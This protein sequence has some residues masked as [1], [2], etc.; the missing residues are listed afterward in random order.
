[1][2]SNARCYVYTELYYNIDDFI[3]RTNK[4]NIL[5]PDYLDTMDRI[6]SGGSGNSALK[7]LIHDDNRQQKPAAAMVADGLPEGCGRPH[8]WLHQ[9]VPTVPSEHP[10]GPD[11]DPDFDKMNQDFRN[12]IR[13]RQQEEWD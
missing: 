9:Q 8:E 7:D 12:R 10:Q 1:M 4:N 11:F 13:S 5:S 2:Y 6:V 3:R